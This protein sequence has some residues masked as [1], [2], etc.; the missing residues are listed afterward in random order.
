MADT[1]GLPG[2]S[3]CS[4]CKPVVSGKAAP[5]DVELTG[6]SKLRL[7]KVLPKKKSLS[8]RMGPPAVPPKLFCTKRGTAIRLQPFAAEKAADDP[9]GQKLNCGSFSPCVKD[10]SQSPV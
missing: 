8:F 5:P 6:P 2:K 9:G 1:P 4:S 7:Q 3:V 10:D